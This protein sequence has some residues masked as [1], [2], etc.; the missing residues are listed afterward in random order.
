MGDIASLN[1]N[2]VTYGLK[3]EVAR[4]GGSSTPVIGY[5]ETG[6]V[7][8]FNVVDP[9]TNSNTFT[10]FVNITGSG[11]IYSIYSVTRTYCTTHSIFN[12]AAEIY[13]DGNCI[14]N[15]TILANDYIQSNDYAKNY[16]CGVN[17]YV[18]PG[19]TYSMNYNFNNHEWNTTNHIFP[20]SI[21]NIPYENHVTNVNLGR[22]SVP[23]CR[24]AAPLI[25]NNN[26]II[27]MRAYSN[28]PTYM[29]AVIG[30]VC[31]FS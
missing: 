21:C 17:L 31:S 4:A 22:Q 12:C 2:G 23:Y 25:F 19:Y 6:Q 9:F 20:N 30:F 15:D 8:I 28:N 27:R 14:V 5:G 24:L 3:D 11:S 18:H 16:F 13:I 7:A 29:A 10:E 26:V 1:I